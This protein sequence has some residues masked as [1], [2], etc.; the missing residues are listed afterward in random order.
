VLVGAEMPA[1][2]VEMGF[3]SNKK[4]EEK[5]TTGEYRQSL[6]QAI[7]EGLESY[8]RSLSHF[9]GRERAAKE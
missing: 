5:L 8:M 4:E 2:L 6:A 9:E 3:L 1:I 7:F